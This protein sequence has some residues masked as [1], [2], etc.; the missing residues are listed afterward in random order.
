[1]LLCAKILTKKELIMSTKE[2]KIGQ[3]VV[4]PTHGVGKIL[5]LIDHKIGNHHLEF[6]KIEFPK[7]KMNLSVPINRAQKI[8][9]RALCDQETINAA[10]EIIADKAQTTRGIMWSRRAQEYERK[11]NSGNI[12]AVSEVIR[13]LHRN[14]KNPDRSYSERMIYENAFYRFV[15]EAAIVTN[16]EQEEFENEF[17]KIL[18]IDDI[19]I[20]NENDLEDEDIEEDLYEE[21]EDEIAAA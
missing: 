18:K 15:S 11:I 7:D 3:Y 13:D 14:V 9:L 19:E 1:M 6:Y 16:Q 21:D 8:G 4:Y 2:F 10:L 17:Y 5:D 20:S 12:L